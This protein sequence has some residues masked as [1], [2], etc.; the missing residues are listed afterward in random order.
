MIFSTMPFG[1]LWSSVF[2]EAP[3]IVSTSPDGTVA[4]FTARAIV[5]KA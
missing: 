1:K 4:P 3:F 2:G 5:G